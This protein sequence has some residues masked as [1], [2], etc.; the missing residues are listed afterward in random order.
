MHNINDGFFLQNYTLLKLRRADVYPFKVM[1]FLKFEMIILD[2]GRPYRAH[3]EC[4]D[5][6]NNRYVHDERH[7]LD[8]S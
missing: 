3:G 2:W 1:L 5:Q 8:N 6:D 4:H 7:S